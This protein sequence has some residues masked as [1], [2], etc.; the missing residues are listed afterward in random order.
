MKKVIAMLLAVVLVLG[1]AACG[2][3]N[4]DA[5][6][7]KKTTSGNE[8][9]TDNQTEGTTGT[10]V[11]SGDVTLDKVL[12][13]NESPESD[14]E[15]LD[16]GNGIVELTKYLGDDEIVVIPSTVNGKEITQIGAYVFANDYHPNTKAVRLSDSVKVVNQ[17]AFGL[18]E[19]L[20]IFVAGSG[21]EEIG[22]GAFQ[23]CTKLSEVVLND[24]LVKLSSACFSDCI[25]LL[26]L[27]IPSSVTD[28]HMLAFYPCADGFT[29]VGM[30]G[31]AAEQHATS[32]GINFK[33]Q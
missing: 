28:I 16:Y 30:A 18:N 1:L 15:I 13:A 5:T 17:G 20:E 27:E 3:G 24:G 8:Q 31:S 6:E 26:S 10:P 11:A 14:F 21:L 12:N 7:P 2:N 19:T 23:S 32:E 33:A 4:G 9:S 25:M 22:D 29:I